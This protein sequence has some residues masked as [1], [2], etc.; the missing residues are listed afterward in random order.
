MNIIMNVLF[1]NR[2]KRSE[3]LGTHRIY[4]TAYEI[5]NFTWDNVNSYCRKKYITASFSLL[6]KIDKGY[7]S[8][9]INT[10]EKIL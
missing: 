10:R 8:L 1:K 6:D 5:Y 9:Y 4:E 7:E 2:K 3:N